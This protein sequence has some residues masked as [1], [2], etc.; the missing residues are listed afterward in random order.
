MRSD[1]LATTVGRDVEPELLRNVLTV[2]DIVGLPDLSLGVA[3]GSEGLGTEIRWLHVSELADPTPWLEGGE[4]LL[5]TGLGVGDLTLM[6]AFSAHGATARGALVAAVLY[7][8]FQWWLPIVGD[9]VLLMAKGAQRRVLAG[10]S[11]DDAALPGVLA[12]AR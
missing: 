5:T 6:H 4:L 9:L 8:V 7:R 12:A 3:A 11:V 10:A 1:R 2:R